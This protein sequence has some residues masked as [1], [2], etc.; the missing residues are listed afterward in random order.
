MH[1]YPNAKLRFFAGDIQLAVN[2]DAAYLVLPGAKNRFA[3]H[4]YLQAFPNN[5]DCNNAPN[6][7]SIHTKCRTIKSVVCSVEEAECSGI[8][9]NGQ[10]TIV[11]RH[12][13]KELGHQQQPTVVKTDNATANSFVHASMR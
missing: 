3:G 10:T 13:L 2:L 7:A 11:I 1:T 6:N 5:L 12:T 4:F 8:F 9:H